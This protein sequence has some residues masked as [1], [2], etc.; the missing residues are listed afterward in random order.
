MTAH[1]VRPRAHIEA[2]RA[3]AIRA[4]GRVA[5]PTGAQPGSLVTGAISWA[6]GERSESPFAGQP[7]GGANS[8]DIDGE[9][10]EC[11]SFLERTPWSTK[12]ADRIDEAQVVI[13]L[14]EWLTGACDV[15]PTYCRETEPGDL[16][17]GR[18][19]IVRSDA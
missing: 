14:L 9:L 11:R 4:A 7:R 17:G 6:L 12:M 16:V 3:D 13:E 15:P 5:A 2:V 18:G 10:R 1:V 8:A 19:R